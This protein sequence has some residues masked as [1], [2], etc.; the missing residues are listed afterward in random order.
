MNKN[1]EKKEEQINYCPNC[2]VKIIIEEVDG[3][4]IK[5]TICIQCHKDIQELLSNILQE[6]LFVK[7]CINCQT[8]GTIDAKFCF[9]CGSEE[10]IKRPRLL[11]KARKLGIKPSEKKSMNPYLRNLLFTNLP[12]IIITIIYGIVTLVW[13]ST[14]PYGLSIFYVIV[15]FLTLFIDVIYGASYIFRTIKRRRKVKRRAK[16]EKF[17]EKKEEK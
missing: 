17:F 6:K 2:G 10:L 15:I 12:M 13:Q 11:K 3:N 14:F 9:N 4:E 8:I 1:E 7:E 5:K 16:L